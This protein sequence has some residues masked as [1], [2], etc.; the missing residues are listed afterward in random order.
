MI[1]RL[2]VGEQASFRFLS[3]THE[4]LAKRVGHLF[5]FFGEADIFLIAVKFVG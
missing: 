5:L 4:T 1:L 3:Q 2:L